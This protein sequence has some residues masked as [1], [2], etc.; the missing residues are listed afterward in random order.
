MEIIISNHVRGY[1]TQH[2]DVEKYL[3]FGEIIIDDKGKVFK[4]FQCL[5]SIEVTEKALEK[6]NNKILKWERKW[7]KKVLKFD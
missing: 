6:V 4:K 1:S 7:L 5:V 3:D 2:R